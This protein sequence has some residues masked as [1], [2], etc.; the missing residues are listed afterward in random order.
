VVVEMD[1]G[2]SVSINACL[3]LPRLAPDARTSDVPGIRLEYSWGPG[4]SGVLTGPTSQPTGG[5]RGLSADRVRYKTSSSGYGSGERSSESIS[6]HHY[7]A[8]GSSIVAATLTLTHPQLSPQSPSQSHP[9]IQSPATTPSG[10]VI[11]P[12][13]RRCRSTCSITLQGLKSNGRASPS[14]Q[15]YP[16]RPFPPQ[17]QQ[18]RQH[19]VPSSLSL[20]LRRSSE[21]EAVAWNSHSKLPQLLASLTDSR[22][23]LPAA[24]IDPTLVASVADSSKDAEVKHILFIFVISN[25]AQIF[26][27]KKTYFASVFFPHYLLLCMLCVL[28]GIVFFELCTNIC[29]LLSRVYDTCSLKV[30]LA[31]EKD[32]CPTISHSRTVS[33]RILF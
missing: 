30:H 28:V 4:G 27:G 20:P 14:G 6:R 13:E 17:E 3:T 5:L 26:S 12:Y 1:R 25:K 21:G 24:T 15:N 8:A 19:N 11:Q 18:Q 22:C 9:P 7:N 29:L 10:R 31:N 2:C 33:F 16:L 23:P 32:L